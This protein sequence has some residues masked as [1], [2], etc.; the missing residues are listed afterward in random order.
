MSVRLRWKSAF[1]SSAKIRV[2]VN[3]SSPRLLHSPS[4]RWIKCPNRQKS[5]DS[6]PFLVKKSTATNKREFASKFG[7]DSDIGW[8][9]GFR[10]R[11]DSPSKS[12]LELQSL[13]PAG[14]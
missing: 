3:A 14:L 10:A 12:K 4:L 13:R 8:R 1:M 6:I 11:W 2:Q 5:R 9:N 7:A